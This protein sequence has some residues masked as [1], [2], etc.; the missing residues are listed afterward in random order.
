MVE[1]VQGKEASTV[2]WLTIASE[3]TYLEQP[4]MDRFIF[5]G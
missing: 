2:A 4:D 1:G 5:I 3:I